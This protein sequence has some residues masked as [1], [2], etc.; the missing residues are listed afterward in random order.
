MKFLCIASAML[1]EF[2][3]PI[4]GDKLGYLE[5]GRFKLEQ[6]ELNNFLQAQILSKGWD[7]RWVIW[8]PISEARISDFPMLSVDDLRYIK[9]GIYQLKNSASYAQRHSTIDN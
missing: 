6:S 2:P 5:L 9:V 3:P 4:R 8:Q 1:N 7:K